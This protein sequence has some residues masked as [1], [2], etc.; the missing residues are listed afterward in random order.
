MAMFGKDQVRASLLDLIQGALM[1]RY[2]KREV[3]WVSAAA[4]GVRHG[5]ERLRR[6]SYACA[7][8]DGETGLG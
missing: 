4:G 5:R 2:N 1:L 7:G 3:G 6:G 8:G